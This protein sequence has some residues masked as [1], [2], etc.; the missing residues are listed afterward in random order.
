MFAR[1][2]TTASLVVLS[3]IRVQHTGSLPRG[4]YR[5]IG[6]APVRGTIGMWCLPRPTAAW[7]HARGYLPTGLGCP[8]GLQPIAKMTLAV[9]G[10]TITM[11]EAGL[12]WNGYTVPRTRPV[13]RDALGRIVPH[14]PFG[15]YVLG[16]GEVW[17]YSPT[18]PRGFDSRYFGPVPERNYVSRLMRLWT[19]EPLRMP[20]LGAAWL[21]VDGV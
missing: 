7:A 21:Q 8:G 16:P 11:T 5:A 3:G 9:A 2:A 10:D 1:L 14:L 15:T 18:T 6:G 17:L 12:V 13:L 4:V 19:T 20:D